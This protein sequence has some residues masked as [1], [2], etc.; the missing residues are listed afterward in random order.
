MIYEVSILESIIDLLGY[1]NLWEESF[2]TTIFNQINLYFYHKEVKLRKTS[3]FAASK[4]GGWGFQSM[5]K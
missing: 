1:F 3:D 4:C 5:C 2:H